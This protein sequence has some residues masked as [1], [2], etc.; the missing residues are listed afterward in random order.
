[1]RSKF[2][3][4]ITGV[5]VT[6]AFVAGLAG[7]AVAAPPPPP[8]DETGPVQPYVVNGRDASQNYSFAT[9]LL[10]PMLDGSLKEF[11]SGSLISR[12][13]TVTAKHC[14]SVIVPGQTRM[15]VGSI[16]LSTGGREVG[17][18]RVVAHGLRRRAA[19]ARSRSGSRDPA[20]SGRVPVL[21]Q[22]RR[23]TS[24]FLRYGL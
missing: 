10:K 14:S 16:K 23:R 18:L 11:C 8:V 17:V 21:D 15:K 1:L 2:R 19:T 5:C 7:A 3:R 6:L 13:W 9:A 12:E 22:A 4:A 20:V 24:A